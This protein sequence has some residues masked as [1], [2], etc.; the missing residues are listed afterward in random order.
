MSDELLSEERSENQAV[1]ENRELLQ[2]AE[3]MNELIK[4]YADDADLRHLGLESRL[5][6]QSAL[7][8]ESGASAPTE[9][10]SAQQIL[11]LSLATLIKP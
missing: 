2:N 7:L 10:E 4:M 11:L 1:T 8:A 6:Q 9:E 5:A 3:E